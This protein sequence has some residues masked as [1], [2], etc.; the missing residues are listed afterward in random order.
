M[1]L[2]FD[3]KVFNPFATYNR[4]APLSFVYRRHE[5]E[6]RGQYEERIRLVERVSY[7][8]LVFVTTGECGSLTTRYLKHLARTLAEKK[9]ERY[10]EVMC[11]LRT[12]LA[13][14]LL[15][16]AIM[17][18]RGTHSTRRS[19]MA[20]RTCGSIFNPVLALHEGGRK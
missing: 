4:S 15:R 19:P 11:W 5:M 18:L 1:E 2:T 9:D 7:T 13:F 10:S 3:V 14:S 12:R 8:P 6:K 16:T 17:C 20:D